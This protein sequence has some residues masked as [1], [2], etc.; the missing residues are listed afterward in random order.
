MIT[1]IK[2]MDQGISVAMDRQQKTRFRCSEYL[3]WLVITQW[4]GST[5]VDRSAYWFVFLITYFQR[6]LE[7]SG[8][9]LDTLIVLH[10]YLQKNYILEIVCNALFRYILLRVQRNLQGIAF[11]FTAY[12]QPAHKCTPASSEIITNKKLTQL[13]FQWQ[14]FSSLCSVQMVGNHALRCFQGHKKDRLVHQSKCKLSLFCKLPR[15]KQSS[16]GLLLFQL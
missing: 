1:M 10:S 16:R 13:N 11:L 12:C 2:I 4:I 3:G 9:V 7:R 15:C 8:G 5:S 14:N 6:Y